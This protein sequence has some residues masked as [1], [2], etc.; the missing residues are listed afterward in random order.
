MATTSKTQTTRK[1]AKPKPADV[2]RL[3]VHIRGESYSV[4]PIRPETPDVARAWRL[5]KADGTTYVIADTIYGA[6]CECGDFVFRHEGK[7]LTG[8][9]HI[10]ACR[11]L[12]LLDSDGDDPADW[13]SWTDTVAFTVT[14]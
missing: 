12:G 10:R 7:T 1:T 13:P 14:R 8:C 11:A 6:T 3:I 5:R 4:R 9:K 2:C